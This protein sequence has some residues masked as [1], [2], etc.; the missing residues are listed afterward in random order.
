MVGTSPPY[1]Y[2]PDHTNGAAS[3]ENQDIAD[4]TNGHLKSIRFASL[5][6]LPVDPLA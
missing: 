5:L 4:P 1:I 6:F 3:V 2:W